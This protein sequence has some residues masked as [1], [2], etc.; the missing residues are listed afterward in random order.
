[1]QRRSFLGLT[2]GTVISTGL[3]FKARPADKGRVDRW[4][5]FRY[6]ADSEDRELKNCKCNLA[7]SDDGINYFF[8]K[9]PLIRSAN[10][11][12]NSLFWDFEDV[13]IES[14]LWWH[15]LQVTTG[16]GLQIQQSVSG[17]EFAKFQQPQHMFPGDVLKSIYTL[18]FDF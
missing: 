18:S 12:P 1:M 2:I 11:N 13:K 9:G 4:G 17:R 16:S 14:E 8:I 6:I 5:I 3:P 7:I 15:G 10:K